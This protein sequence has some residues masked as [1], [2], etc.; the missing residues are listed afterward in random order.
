VSEIGAV[1][2]FVK[3]EWSKW[4]TTTKEEWKAEFENLEKCE[5]ETRKPRKNP[6]GASEK[7]G[8]EP[9]YPLRASERRVKFMNNA[10]KFQ[11]HQFGKTSMIEPTITN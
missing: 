10:L 4:R 6:C 7:K 3:R 1:R 2:K 9:E 8:P 5:F 11:F